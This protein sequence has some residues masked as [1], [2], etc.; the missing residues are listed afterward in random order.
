MFNKTKPNIVISETD[1]DAALVYL[2]SLPYREALPVSW[3]RQ[4]LLNSLNETIG[5]NPRID[6]CYA[7]GPGLYAIIKPCGADTAYRGEPDGR[8]QVWLLIRPCGTDPTRMVSL[9]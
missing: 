2:R 8:L 1:I 3:D 6:E 7:I 4:H 9:Q 5:L